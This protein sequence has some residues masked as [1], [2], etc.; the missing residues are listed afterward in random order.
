M[1]VRPFVHS[2]IFVTLFVSA[3]GS[4]PDSETD[5]SSSDSVGSTDTT[6]G[7]IVG[8]T[9]TTSDGSSTDISGG[10]VSAAF[11]GEWEIPCNAAGGPYSETDH[12]SVTE[13]GVI[14]TYTQHRGDP[15]CSDDSKLVIKM[16]ISDSAWS[17]GAA[18]GEGFALDKVLASATIRIDE[19]NAKSYWDSNAGCGP[20]P[21]GEDKDV[22]AMR[23]YGAWYPAVG[24]TYYTIVSVQ[25]DTMQ[26]G[27]WEGGESAATRTDS[28]DPVR[29]WRRVGA[30]PKGFIRGIVN[31][32]EFIA[33]EN[34]T[35][36]AVINDHI[37]LGA[38]TRPLSPWETWVLNVP[39]EVGVHACDDQA[40]NA[41][42]N[43]GFTDDN[44][45]PVL[46]DTESD[47][48]AGCS[49]TVTK[50]APAVGD[51]LEGTF[52]GIVGDGLGN[53][54]TVGDGKFEIVRL[55]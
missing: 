37:Q 49:I 2:A 23:C 38:T 16:V 46:W 43:F 3:C 44:D 9:D 12:L 50:A 18:H 22:S 48:G 5:T 33:E 25:G 14:Y 15:T 19:E 8:G 7:D 31:G 13:T 35:A 17:V 21:L 51:K 42:I 36:R 11:L 32:N 39:N 53:G 6:S 29:V 1:Q 40:I 10:S 24:D 4:D 55:E 26:L 45:L 20:F 41:Y 54:Y 30:E 28:L 34:T 52:E 47:G 27:A